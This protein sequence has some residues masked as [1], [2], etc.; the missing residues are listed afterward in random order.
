[1]GAQPAGAY[2][3]ALEDGEGGGGVGGGGGGW[4]GR[5]V[6]QGWEG[7]MREYPEKERKQ[8]NDQNH[9]RWGS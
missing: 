2:M 3:L 7:E 8:N 9:K 1:M 6:R 4:Y 5:G